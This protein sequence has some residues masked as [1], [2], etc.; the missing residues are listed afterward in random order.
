VIAFGHGYLMTWSAYAWFWSTVVPGGYIVALPRTEGGL[1][2]SHGAFGLDLAFVLRQM[3]AEGT[4][5]GS[6]FFGRVAERNA[7]M[8]H[9]MG[10]GASV[11]AAAGDATIT[12]VANLAAAET[13]PSAVAAAAAIGAPAL[14]LAGSFDCVAPPANHQRPIYEALG[15]GCRSY[16]EL[17]GG[18]HCQFADYNFNCSLGEGSCPTPGLSRAAQQALVMDYLGPWLRHFLKLDPAGWTEFEARRLAGAGIT[19][20]QECATTGVPEGAAVAGP[21]PFG[22]SVRPN[23]S[24]SDVVVRFRLPEPGPARLEVLDVAGRPVA[25]LIDGPLEEGTHEV[26]WRDPAPAGLYLLRLT[27]GARSETWKIVRAR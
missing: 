22:L 27:A 6:L 13:N 5:P 25:R 11:L 14:V 1:L 15:S 8:G 9:S 18:S 26:E 3:S 24:R 2:P 21:S 20:L 17:I 19:S 12:A 7:V 16:V 23:P 10:G 4:S